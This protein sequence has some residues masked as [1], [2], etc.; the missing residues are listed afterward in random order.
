MNQNELISKALMFSG[1][2]INKNLKITSIILFGSVARGDFDN[3]SDIDLFIE[4]NG[5]EK[6]ILASLNL[7][8]NSEINRGYGLKG[9]SN[10]IVLKIGNFEK[11]ESLKDS[12][13]ADGIQL[14]GKYQNAPEKTEFKLLYKISTEKIPRKK[15]IHAWRQLYGYIQAANKKKYHYKGILELHGGEKIANSVFVISAK[16]K[17]AIEKFLKENKLEYNMYEYWTR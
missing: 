3:E 2:L 15:Q 9:I 11:W 12:I 17:Y 6:E 16:S 4:T 13:L 1:F 10:E 14:Y 8:N 7:F 5:P